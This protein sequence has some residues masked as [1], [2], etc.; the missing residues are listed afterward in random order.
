MEKYLYELK[1]Y[2]REMQALCLNETGHCMGIEDIQGHI[3]SEEFINKFGLM[4][5]TFLISLL[6][7]Q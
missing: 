3:E 2:L 7:L 1:K 4:D 6:L 5:M